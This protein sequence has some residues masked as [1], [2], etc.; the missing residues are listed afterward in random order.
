MHLHTFTYICIHL[1][2]FAYICI[3]LHT[4]AYICIHFHT[5]AYICIHFVQLQSLDDGGADV[6]GGRDDSAEGSDFSESPIV[7]PATPASSIP[8][9]PSTEQ[10]SK[11]K[12]VGTGLKAP[13]TGKC[14]R[15]TISFKNRCVVYLEHYFCMH[16]YLQHHQ[17][18]V[19]PHL[20]NVF[21][22]S[23][24]VSLLLHTFPS[25]L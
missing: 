17:P 5:F 11:K 20:F 22:A 19:L 7:A 25:Y 6:S 23:I 2:T 16:I 15:S 3:H 13:S 8:R 10:I 24:L 1:H 14:N 9:T 21:F 12:P 4:F 18:S